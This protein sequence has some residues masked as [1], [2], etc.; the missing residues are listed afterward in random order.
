M[1]E[2]SFGNGVLFLGGRARAFRLEGLGRDVI[3]MGIGTGTHWLNMLETISIS[4]SAAAIFS[5]EEGWGRALPKRK[6]IF[7]VVCVFV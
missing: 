3:G 6:D 2:V 1:E 5:A 7:S 4:A